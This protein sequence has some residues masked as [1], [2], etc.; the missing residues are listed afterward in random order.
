MAT[1]DTSGVSNL[2]GPFMGGSWSVRVYEEG[3]PPSKLTETRVKEGKP[4][5]AKDYQAVVNEACGQFPTQRISGSY[6]DYK[7]D[8]S[9]QSRYVHPSMTRKDH[10]ST[11]EGDQADMARLDGRPTMMAGNVGMQCTKTE[12]AAIKVTFCPSSY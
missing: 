5:G 2:H 7:F 4:G 9:A 8:E 1:I 11:Y 6:P 3:T 12:F 10:A